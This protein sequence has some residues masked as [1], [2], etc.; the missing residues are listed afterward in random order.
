MRLIYSLAV[1]GLALAAVPAG[2]QE[3]V[4]AAPMD[5]AI[6]AGDVAA[7]AVAQ[8]NDKADAAE[9]QQKID[10]Y[11]QLMELNGVT[12]NIRNVI[13]A[14]KTATRLVIIDRA[15]VDKLTPEQDAR[16]NQ[17]A[18]NVLSATQ[19]ELI[20]AVASAQAQ[21][22]TA[23][24]IHQLITANASPAA[25]KYNAVKFLTPDDNA[26]AVQNYMVDAVVKIVKTWSQAQTG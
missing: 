24:E 12:Q 9:A 4:A 17:I 10:L 3:I 2:A 21:N 11:K 7:V 14:T 13:A 1:L 6:A 26:T 5:R 18:D 20:N 15:G 25:A 19:A 23:D 16:Y 22:F 8:I